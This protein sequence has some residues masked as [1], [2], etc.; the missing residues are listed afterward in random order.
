MFNPLELAKGKGIKM[1]EKIE[2]I[3]RLIKIIQPTVA[4]FTTLP[5]IHE[6]IH[7]LA[8]IKLAVVGA[9]NLAIDEIMD[10]HD[11]LMADNTEDVVDTE[12][13]AVEEADGGE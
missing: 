4:N 3:D 12:D 11:M 6:R 2:K 7:A 10:E 8:N 9:I 5:G 13:T 1:N